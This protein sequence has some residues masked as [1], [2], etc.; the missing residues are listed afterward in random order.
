[1]YILNQVYTLQSRFSDIEFS[2]NLR[3]SGYLAKIYFSIYNIKLLH[4]LRGLICSAIK[5]WVFGTDYIRSENQN[6]FSCLQ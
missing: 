2:D 3:F 6:F 4:L 5:N 1:M